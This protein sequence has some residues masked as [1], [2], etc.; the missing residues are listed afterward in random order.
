[1]AWEWC[2]A[3]PAPA[4]GSPAG[5]GPAQ[6]PSAHC[7]CRAPRCPSCARAPG[8]APPLATP[9]RRN[10]LAHRREA[11][12]LSPQDYSL[13]NKLGATLANSSRS[14]DAIAAYQKVWHG[15]CAV[16][17]AGTLRPE[18][19]ACPRAG[20]PPP[21]QPAR[22]AQASLP[23]L[24]APPAPPG[25]ALDLKPNYMRA[26]TNMGISLANLTDYDASARYYVRALALNPKASAG[27][28]GQCCRPSHALGAGR[29]G[30]R[31]SSVLSGW[32]QVG[33]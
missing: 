14:A 4:A 3:A 12:R 21:R 19:H 30:R 8:P 17:R 7:P 18:L 20:R 11:L 32:G 2:S 16:P 22:P 23:L 9:R 33:G 15:P 27:G 26:W 24:L 10:P 13:W 25:Q 31:L 29:T 6:R 28:W 5:T 1:M